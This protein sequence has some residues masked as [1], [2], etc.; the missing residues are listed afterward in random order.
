MHMVPKKDGSWRP[1]GDYSHLNLVTT[2]DKYPLPN[3]Q[4]LSNGLHG[5]TVFSKLILSRVITKSLLRPKTSPNCN[6][7]AIWFVQISFHTFWTV[8][9]CTNFPKNDGANHRWSGRCVCVHGRLMGW[10][11]GQAN[12]PPPSVGFLQ[13]LY[14][15]GLKNVVADFLSRPPSQTTGSVAAT[16]AADPVDY[17]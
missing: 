9:R 13:L 1:C 5:C 4:D 12:T 17:K 11:S 15:P 10:F 2:Q 14:L 8:Q 3:M 6:H 16:T 7:N